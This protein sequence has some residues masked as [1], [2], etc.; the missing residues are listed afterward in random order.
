MRRRSPFVW[1]CAPKRVCPRAKWFWRRDSGPRPDSSGST[2]LEEPRKAERSF[3][4]PKDAHQ[5][6]DDPVA[7]PKRNYHLNVFLNVKNTV[8]VFISLF[9]LPISFRFFCIFVHHNSLSV[10]FLLLHIAAWEWKSGF[11]NFSFFK[12]R[13]KSEDTLALFVWRANC[14]AR[15][16][17][18]CGPLN[19]HRW[20]RYWTLWN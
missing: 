5:P 12:N 6:N 10:L 4:C 13:P 3:S 9:L 14:F 17:P 7:K 19:G 2:R 15:W 20:M 18:H 1:K 11:L 16:R 8:I